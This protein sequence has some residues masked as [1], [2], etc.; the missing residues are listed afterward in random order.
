[1]FVTNAMFVLHLCFKDIVVM[2]CREMEPLGE[3]PIQQQFLIYLRM[4]VSLEDVIFL[5]K[6]SMRTTRLIPGA[7]CV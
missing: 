7:G 5:P 1:M 3:I 2:N 4:I 6:L